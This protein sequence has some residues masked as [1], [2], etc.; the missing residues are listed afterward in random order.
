M[1]K[2]YLKWLLLF[3]SITI[4]SCDG[5]KS[6]LTEIWWVV[7]KIKIVKSEKTPKLNW[8]GITFYEN[9]TCQLPKIKW[10]DDMNATWEYIKERENRFVIIKSN[11]IFNGK[12]IYYLNNDPVTVF[13]MVLI[14]DSLE[15]TCAPAAWSNIK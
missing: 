10:T 7:T 3:L 6:R 13:K 14:S 8:N 1:E 5:F 9:G 2:Y 4:L 11:N 15:I 12:Y